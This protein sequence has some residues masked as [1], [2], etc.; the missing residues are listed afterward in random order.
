M[1]YLVP[2]VQISQEFAQL[3][4][5]VASPLSALIIGPH[6][7]LLRYGVASEKAST[8]VVDGS[9][10][11]NFRNAN[12]LTGTAYYSA[13]DISY[14]YPSLATGAAVD[15]A[16]TKVYADRVLAQY[17]PHTAAPVIAV[18]AAS[19]AN[20][21]DTA[22]PAVANQI[23]L[24]TTTT[25]VGGVT[26]VEGAL[27]LLKDQSTGTQNGLYTFAASSGILTRAAAYDTTGELG[28]QVIRVDGGTNLNLYFVLK[29]S[30]LPV[31]GTDSPTYVQT[32]KPTLGQRG[33]AVVLASDYA[34]R[35]PNRLQVA[36]CLKT[37]NSIPRSTTFSGRDVTVGDTIEITNGTAT[38]TTKIKALHAS[39]VPLT[40]SSATSTVLSGEGVTV[41]QAGQLGLVGAG[42]T[43]SKPITYT[44]TTTRSGAFY[45]D[46]NA[47]LCG[48]VRIT[49][50]GVDGNAAEVLPKTGSEFSLGTLG[51]KSTFNAVAGVLQVETGT[52]TGTVTGVA[53]ATTTLNIIVTGAGIAGSPVTVSVNVVTGDNPAAVADKIRLA[54]AVTT[55]G[56]ASAAIRALYDIIGTGADYALQ[57]KAAVANDATLNLALALGTATGVTASTTSTDTFKGVQPLNS[58]H[59]GKTY[60]VT[61]TPASSAVTNI[62]ETADAIWL[63]PFAV[64]DATLSYRLLLS[65]S[66]VSLPKLRA[67]GSAANW[68]ATGSLVTVD[69][70][71]VVTDS[72]ITDGVNPLD[73]AINYAKLYVEYR[74]LRKDKTLTIGVVTDLAEVETALGAAHPDNPL[75]EGVYD[76][77]LNSAGVPVYY[78]GV[79]SDDI[80][81]YNKALAL[82]KR[83]NL[84]YGL[85]P[86]TFNSAIQD[87]VV[88]HVNALSTKN[89]AKWRVAW[90]SKALAPTGVVYDLKPDGVTDWLGYVTDDPADQTTTNKTLFIAAG[91]TFAERGAR[92][93]DTLEVN[94][95]L[96]PSSTPVWDSFPVTEVRSETTLVIAGGYAVDLGTPGSPVKFRLQHN[97]TADEQI[98]KLATS[99]ANYDNRR[100]RV[101]FPDTA[102][103][104][105]LV[106]Q[107]YYVAAALA[108]LRSGV[109]PHQGLTN[110]PLLGFDDFDKTVNQFNQTQLDTLASKGFWL[111][112]QDAV[113]ST[114]YTRHQLTSDE[115]NLNFSEDSVTANVDSISYGLQAALSPFIGSYNVNPGTLYLVRASIVSQL[116]FRMTN[117][118]TQRAGNQLLGYEIK[119]LE[120]STTFKDKIMVSIGLTLPYP[121]NFTDLTLE[122]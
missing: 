83:L 57:A 85:V 95:R 18:A 116:D 101:V 43:G 1:P 22:S 8:A 56:T 109:V 5:F 9:F 3:P 122:V 4:V 110:T 94:F 107:G 44:I 117:T 28:H 91:A 65:K 16:Y 90:L 15:A 30:T 86:L 111:V 34:G 112:T 31:I 81:G 24:A 10:G 47:D 88:S 78:V 6:Y 93:G 55:A 66:S 27:V 62:I 71:A 77:L 58:F 84:Y 87:A 67:G 89:E 53:G 70:L 42:Y 121:N 20:A 26:L 13:L 45:N 115:S 49:S 108:G 19:I 120:Q 35:Y 118:F 50:N 98:A 51:A 74:A 17:F 7:Q 11:N 79:D 21:A 39:I 61:I 54:L 104:A 119:R 100:V 41:L 59:A 48:K 92:A 40:S 73:L 63:N 52:V 12:L 60:Q 25:P 68:S 106:K 99:G 96:D 80:T 14:A 103:T 114:A 23:K 97:H 69:K 82:A 64:D 46:S 38:L 37:A 33:G 2:R 105:G 32:F 76:A 72:Q 36:G 29:N 75:S 102:K 113:G